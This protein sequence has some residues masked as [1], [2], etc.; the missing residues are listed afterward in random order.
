MAYQHN[1]LSRKIY[2]EDVKAT[3]LAFVLSDGNLQ[4]IWDSCYLIWESTEQ[5]MDPTSYEN[6][7]RE[8]FTLTDSLLH[9][10]R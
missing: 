3:T 7:V 6:Q 2:Y 8:H 1:I 10:I 5:L 4:A 9:N